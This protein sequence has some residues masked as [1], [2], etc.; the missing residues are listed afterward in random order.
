MRDHMIELEKLQELKPE[1]THQIEELVEDILS[2]TKQIY[3]K[4]VLRTKMGNYL[5]EYNES[6]DELMKS[7]DEK[8]R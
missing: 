3:R 1:A 2:Q 8:F 6:E 5:E 7:I 4:N